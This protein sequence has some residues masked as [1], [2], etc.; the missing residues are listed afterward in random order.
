[1]QN[2]T[3]KGPDGRLKPRTFLLWANRV[4]HQAQTGSNTQVFLKQD[5]CQCVP[6]CLCLFVRSVLNSPSLWEKLKLNQ[7]WGLFTRDTLP[8]RGWCPHQWIAGSRCLGLD[9]PVC[10]GSLLAAALRGVGPALLLYFSLPSAPSVKFFPNFIFFYFFFSY[11]PP[12]LSVMALYQ[13][14]QSAGEVLQVV[15]SIQG[16]GRGH[17]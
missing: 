4:N 11:R 9:T 2:S 10:T 14:T 17:R 12:V 15:T 3:Q 13:S 5:V 1:M 8:A 7:V 6:V 16:V